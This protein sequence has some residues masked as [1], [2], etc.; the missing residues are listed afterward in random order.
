M[1]FKASVAKHLWLSR[2]DISNHLD[3][4]WIACIA[5]YDSFFDVKQLIIFSH[6]PENTGKLKEKK[7][8]NQ[9]S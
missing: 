3:E 6:H 9:V 2:P 4:A 8:N 7:E 1:D 5:Y